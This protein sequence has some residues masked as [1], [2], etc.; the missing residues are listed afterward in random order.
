LCIHLIYMAVNTPAERNI[1]A[2]LNKARVFSAFRTNIMLA[3]KKQA[4]KD[5]TH[6][7]TELILCKYMRLGQCSLHIL[8]DWTAAQTNLKANALWCHMQQCTLW[9]EHTE[10]FAFVPEWEWMNFIT[11]R[12]A[13]CLANNIN[14]SWIFI[15]IKMQ[16]N[17][18]A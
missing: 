14:R 2:L 5:Q 1:K 13:L 9:K 15:C 10:L 11:L 18:H 8:H 3:L 16:K 12:Y 6:T 7:S 4:W 17:I